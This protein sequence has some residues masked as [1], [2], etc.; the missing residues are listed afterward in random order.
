MLCG[1]FNFDEKDPAFVFDNAI[2]FRAAVGAEMIHRVV[3]T[4]L[5]KMLH[6]LQNDPCLENRAMVG[7]GEYPFRCTYRQQMAYSLRWKSGAR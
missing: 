1:C 3:N 6:D 7:M 4:C 5:L 2:D